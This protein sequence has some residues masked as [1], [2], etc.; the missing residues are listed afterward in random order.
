MSGDRGGS[1]RQDQRSRGFQRERIIARAN[2]KDGT[3]TR[4]K[5]LNVKLKNWAMG[6]H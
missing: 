1:T 4:V 5:A 6:S 3:A 2:W